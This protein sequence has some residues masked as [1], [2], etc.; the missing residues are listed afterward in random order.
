[1]NKNSFKVHKI[2]SKNSK[3]T[4]KIKNKAISNNNY[5]N[6]LNFS[7]NKPSRV[8]INSKDKKPLRKGISVWMKIVLLQIYFKNCVVQKTKKR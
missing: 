4:L 8:T 3:K 1:M 5:K 7:K 2:T 6:Q